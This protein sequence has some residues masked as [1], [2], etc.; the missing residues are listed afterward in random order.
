M[1]RDIVILSASE[2]SSDAKLLEIPNIFA[3]EDASLALSMTFRAVWPKEMR[4]DLCGVF[5]TQDTS[6]LMKKS[7]ALV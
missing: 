1:T 2:G 3:V 4:Q 6:R 7:L 5:L